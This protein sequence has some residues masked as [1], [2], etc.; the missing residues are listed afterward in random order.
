MTGHPH[1]G[2]NLHHP[3]ETVAGPLKDPVCGMTVTEHHRIGTSTGVALLLQRKVQGEV[4][5]RPSNTLPP[6]AAA[7]PP[8]T[9]PRSTSARCTRRSGGPAGNLPEVRDGARAR[10]AERRRRGESRAR[11]TS[12]GASGGPCRSRS[13]SPCSRCSAISSGGSTWR[14][15]AGSSSCCRCRSSCGLAGRSSCAAPSRSRTA[16]PTCGR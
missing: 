12:G 6:A 15:R 5:S 7:P 14:R 11:W 3:T 10:A 1:D 16:V 13:S 9:R 2:H 4:R 8:T